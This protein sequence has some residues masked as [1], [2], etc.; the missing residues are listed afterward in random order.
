MSAE[1]LLL[2][3]S[4]IDAVIAVHMFGNLC[5]MPSLEEAAQGKPIIEDCAQSLG[6]KINRRMAGS[7]GAIGVFSF[8]SGKNPSVGEGGALFTDQPGIRSR[9]SQIIAAMS[10]PSRVD[11]C[12]HVIITY[13]RSKFRSRPL[14]GLVGSPLWSMYNRKV[15]YSSKSPI[16]MGQTYSSDF[17]ITI[18]RLTKLEYSIEKQR[19]NADFYSRSLTL[20]PNMLC[21][22]KVGTYYNRHLYPITF[23]ST[24]QRDLIASYLHSR[25]IG[26][27]QPYKDIADVATT[28]YGYTGDCPVAEQIAKRVLVIPS[29]YRLSQRDVHRVAQCLNEGWAEV[30][31]R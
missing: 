25:Q 17:A 13:I 21:S 11:E 24:E 26:T 10:A 23:P 27:I 22:E 16:V 6:S 28:Y 4:Q 12:M 30:A 29:Y 18:N 15:D 14:W 3:T 1:D 2:K 19:T 31:S 9:L 7:F 20:D 5:D 8:R